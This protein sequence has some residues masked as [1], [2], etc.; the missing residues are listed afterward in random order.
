LSMIPIEV[1]A[2][3]HLSKERARVVDIARA[4]DLNEKSVWQTLKRLESR[5]LVSKDKFDVYDITNQGRNQLEEAQA[6]VKT[7][8]LTI[9]ARLQ[10]SVESG[11]SV[12]ERDLK[13]LLKKVGKSGESQE[14][15]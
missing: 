6:D 11:K 10:R 2:L 12:S 9:I 3:E 13:E 1:M 8:Q 7:R 5:G 4:E 14:E 15:R